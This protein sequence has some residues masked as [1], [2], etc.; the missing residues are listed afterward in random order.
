M[1]HGVVDSGQRSERSVLTGQL[2]LDLVLVNELEDVWRIGQQNSTADHGDDKKDVQL[3]SVNDYG[4]VTPVI[5]HLHTHTH[6]I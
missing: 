1:A 2:S 6:T 5:H 3:H 4:D